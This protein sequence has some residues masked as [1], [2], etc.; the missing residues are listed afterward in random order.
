MFGDLS[1]PITA[2]TTT[3]EKQMKI[4]GGAIVEIGDSVS[5]IGHS[6]KNAA[7]ALQA[8]REVDEGDE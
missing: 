3:L 8:I 1:L 6:I 5:E 2:K 4:I 7:D